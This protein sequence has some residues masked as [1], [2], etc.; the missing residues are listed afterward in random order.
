MRKTIF[1]IWLMPLRFP[2]V[3]SLINCQAELTL[4]LFHNEAQALR[5]NLTRCSSRYWT[6]GVLHVMLFKI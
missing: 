5:R 4:S 6:L 2:E 3:S 1:S